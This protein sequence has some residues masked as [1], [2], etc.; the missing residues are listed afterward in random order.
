M[1]TW[2]PRSVKCKSC[3]Q[4]HM[5]KCQMPNARSHGLHGNNTAK[6]PNSNHNQLLDDDTEW[7]S[8]L[9]EAATFQMPSQLWCLFAT[10]CI[11][12]NLQ[13]QLQL[14]QDHK[15]FMAEDYNLLHQ[16]S[17][18]QAEKKALQDIQAILLQAGTTCL[19]IGLP[20]S[21]CCYILQWIQCAK[22][23]GTCWQEHGL[24]QCWTAAIGRCYSWSI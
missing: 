23:R 13:N 4:S 6:C 17:P 7:D 11:H 16:L 10:I 8:T 21:E 22:G 3:D 2:L 1:V 15:H 9:T 18:D 12:C 20:K 5:F 19:S 24:T 14:W